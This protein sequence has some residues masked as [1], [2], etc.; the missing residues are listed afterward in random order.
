M[1]ESPLSE[2]PSHHHRTLS[3]ME[4][5]TTERPKMHQ[6]RLSSFDRNEYKRKMYN[7]SNTFIGHDKAIITDINVTTNPT[8]PTTPP[9]VHTIT[10]VNTFGFSSQI[11]S[12]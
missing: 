2:T 10:L 8:N 5:T 9:T 4:R 1:M 6:R 12:P 7:E 3:N 11:L